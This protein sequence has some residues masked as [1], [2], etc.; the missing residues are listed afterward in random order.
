MITDET[1]TAL[2]ATDKK[3]VVLGGGRGASQVLLGARPYFADLTAV[4]A[5]TD[6]GRSTGV[7]RTLADIPAPGDLRNTLTALAHD[8]E[9]LLPRLLEYR[10][11]SATFPALDGMAFG[12]LLLAALTQMTGDFA[13]AVATTA[14]LIGCTAR[15]LP[16]STANTHLCAELEDGRVM[17]NE[18]EVRGLHKA[19]I[20]RL[21]LADPSAPTYPPVLEAL[22]QA[23][24][25]VIGPGS[26]FTSVLAT[27]LFDGLVT[28][29]R[30]TRAEVVFVCNTTTQ[31]GQTDH[32]R[33]I[34]HVQRVTEL[35]GSGVLNTV[36]V[37]RSEVLDLELLAQYAVEGIH[38][39]Q[40]T[41]AEL[42]DIAAQGIRTLVQDYAEMTGG[43]REL[44]NKQDTIRHD[45]ALIGL[46][47]YKLALDADDAGA[48]MAR[49]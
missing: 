47:L 19:P 21:F 39:L 46:A 29:L 41:D 33:V 22:A 28:A 35:L 5:V 10:L 7:A 4:V 23:D 27:L 2:P 17:Q 36:L 42:A 1:K 18:L 48:S 15:V 43:K 13:G 8:P 3:L 32:Y 26:L 6:T 20:R 24:M 45:P 44:W 25:V 12:N 14:T 11:R 31:P 16:I 37:N 34:D 49:S 40:P 9:A 38:L 30:Q